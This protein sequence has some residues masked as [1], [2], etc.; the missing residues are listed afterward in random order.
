MKIGASVVY[1]SIIAISGVEDGGRRGEG[2][3][4]GRVDKRL[5]DGGLDLVVGS[6]L[7]L[8]ASINKGRKGG[9]GDEGEGKQKLALESDV[10]GR[11]SHHLDD[12]N[13][14]GG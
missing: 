5:S 7:G 3:G 13:A 14:M 9:E 12:D 2:E 11:P 8:L 4:L 10:A 1:Q 6:L